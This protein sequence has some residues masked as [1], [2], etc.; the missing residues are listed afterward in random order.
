MVLRFIMV[1]LVLA[2]PASARAQPMFNLVDLGN[3]GGDNFNWAT[4][5]NN[6]GQVIGGATTP[7]LYSIGFRTAPGGLPLSSTV[8]MGLDTSADAI[9]ASG[10]ITGM[11]HSNLSTGAAPWYAYRTSA[12]GVYGPGTSLGTLPGAGN[13]R[14]YGIN[15][16]GQV[17]GSVDI[18]ATST[19]RATSMAFRT[20][21]TGTISPATQLGMFPGAAWDYFGGN[22][23]PPGS[24]AFAIN[25]SGQTTG[26]SDTAT[27]GA[28]RAFR[29]SSTGL[30]SDP[31]TDLGMLPGGSYNYG[32]GSAGLAI[33]NSGQVAGYSYINTVINHIDSHHAFRTTPTGLVT[34]A[35]ADLGTLP[36]GLSSAATGINALGEVVGDSSVAVG[37]QHAFLYT[38]QMWD[39]NNL[40]PPTSGWLLSRAYGINDNLWIAGLAFVDS[41]NSQH[42]FLLIP[43]EGTPALRAALYTVVPEPSSF[44]LGGVALT[45]GWVIRRR[46]LARAQTAATAA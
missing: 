28:A 33:N 44:A 30:I 23:H 8:S 25:S 9:N 14:G 45:V 26:W 38:N 42:A 16:S 34:D 12:T 19:A 10:Q 1:G 20:S 22:P 4:G 40:I 35:G 32:M 3:I 46:R 15:A 7:D 39:L 36:G 31:G 27:P 43:A 6:A 37:R 17:V 21:A 41:S 18:P 2:I 5:I 29:T 24:M 11:Y 13:S